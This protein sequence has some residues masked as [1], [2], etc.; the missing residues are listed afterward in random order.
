MPRERLALAPAS[1]LG[2]ARRTHSGPSLIRVPV[3]SEPQCIRHQ[4]KH[5]C[6]LATTY[7]HPEAATKLELKTVL[8]YDMIEVITEFKQRLRV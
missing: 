7:L 3:P 1:I 2:Q 4:Q 8:L 5:T 6:N